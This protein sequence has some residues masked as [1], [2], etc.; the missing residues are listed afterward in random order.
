[1]K[2]MMMY[3]LCMGMACSAQA[4][5]EDLVITE[6]KVTPT[7]QEFVEI[8]NKGVD[9]VSL[10]NVYLTDATFS[11]GNSRHYHLKKWHQLNT[12]W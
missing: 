1:M 9:T 4:G 3:W 10:T 12:H 6:I 11:N 2:R 8:H 5:L 7:T